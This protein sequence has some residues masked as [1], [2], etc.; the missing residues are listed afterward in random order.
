MKLEPRRPWCQ[1]T[2][3][4]L[5]F[6]GDRPFRYHRIG[7]QGKDRRC[8]TTTELTSMGFSTNWRGIW[9]RGAGGTASPQ[10][11]ATWSKGGEG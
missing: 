6:T 4:G 2:A 8:R 5:T 7:E 11:P 10:A 3:C 1:C 9:T